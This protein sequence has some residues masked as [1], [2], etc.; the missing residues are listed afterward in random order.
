MKIKN[1]FC[2]FLTTILAGG[3]ESAPLIVEDGELEI[4]AVGDRP[5]LTNFILTLEVF[6]VPMT[7]AAEAKRSRKRDALAYREFLAATKSGKGIYDK[8][9]EARGV[10]TKPVRIEEISEY[11]YPTEYDPPEVGKLPLKL[12]HDFKDFDK[13]ITPAMPTSFETKKL[14]DTVE[15]TFHENDGEIEGVSGTLVYTHVSLEKEL[16]W[17]KEESKVKM[18]QFEVQKIEAS[19]VL[20]FGET[21]F[22]GSL[23]DP[24]KDP[25]RKGH[26]WVVFVTASR[27]APQKD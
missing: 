17:G 10:V 23:S 24:S 2:L 18:P 16:E 26:V 20:P 3:Q 15:A 21:L 7:L 13:F 11:I 19:L 1:L 9:M 12:P 5:G 8:F 4:P 6:S 14:G 22:V 27:I 25:A